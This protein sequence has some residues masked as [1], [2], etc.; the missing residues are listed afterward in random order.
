M[1]QENQLQLAAHLARNMTVEDFMTEDS[2]FVPS[3]SFLEGMEQLCHR[4]KETQK[5]E[6]YLQRVACFF[7]ALLLGCTVWLTLDVKARAA[8][9]GWIQERIQSFYHYEYSGEPTASR[10]SFTLGW[11]PEGYI[12]ESRTE[13][14]AFTTETY[15]NEDG[16]KLTF[17][18]STEP[19]NL[20]LYLTDDGQ[21]H[22]T[23]SV[24][25]TSADFYKAI[26]E[27]GRNDLVWVENDQI[28]F[29]ISSCS[30]ES[31]LVKMAENMIYL[32]K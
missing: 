21:T 26:D 18:Y 29:V 31:Y 8:F 17:T 28:L 19:E 13:M 9:I 2:V 14:R 16:R 10:Q 4:T 5:V 3:A 32:E 11:V 6:K 27:T 20:D 30:N 22:R 12:L 7:L 24:N 25:G 15:I 23:V 1:I